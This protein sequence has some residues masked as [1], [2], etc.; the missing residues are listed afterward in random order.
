M[1]KSRVIASAV[2]GVL[3]FDSFLFVGAGT[4]AYWQ[5]WLYVV[6]SLV[7]VTLNQVMQPPG[8]TMHQERVRGVGA[9]EAWDKRLLGAVF[10]VS[11]A[12]YLIAGLDSGRFGW[13]GPVPLAVTVAG[14]ALM[15]SG[16]LLFALAM[17]ENRFFSSTVRLQPELGQSVCETGPY[18]YVRH[19][20]YSGMAV[21]LLTFPLVTGSWW[22]FIPALIALGLL[23]A[24]TLL[25]DRML[26]AGLPGYSDYA[27]R[28]RY[29]L[30]PMIF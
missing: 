30:V 23:I 25:E 18:R 20:G 16:Q 28:T 12:M 3:F 21:G 2:L 15:L 10:V 7:G 17:R 13:S 11:I 6:L 26:V 22:A 5:G 14:V 27:E 1:S 29:R 24:R 8:S 19:P 9:G 4:L